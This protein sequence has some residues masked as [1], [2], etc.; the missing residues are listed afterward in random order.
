MRTLTVTIEI[1]KE[2]EKRLAICVNGVQKAESV[3]SVLLENTDLA[4]LY[5]KAEELNKDPQDSFEFYDYT[6]EELDEKHA[7]S[8]EIQRQEKWV[9][10][11]TYKLRRE[12]NTD[13]INF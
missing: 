11:N 7:V 2:L 5:K 3:E 10:E 4:E 8:K 13:P 9:K 6:R 1:R 12:Y